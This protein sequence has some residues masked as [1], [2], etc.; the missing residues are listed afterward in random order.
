M[1]SEPDSRGL[2][3][4]R[5][6]P[7]PNYAKHPAYGLLFGRVTLQKRLAAIKQ[8]KTGLAKPIFQLRIHLRKKIKRNLARLRSRLL[9]RPTRE[10]DHPLLSSLGENGAVSDEL[11]IQDMEP[12]YNLLGKEIEA[13]EG[14]REEKGDGA[15]GFME[16]VT[17]FNGLDHPELMDALSALFER[18]GYLELLSGYMGYDL[19]VSN[20]NLQINNA[21]DTYWDGRFDD[22]DVSYPATRYMHID[23]QIGVLKA[24]IYLSSVTTESGPFCYVMGSN[25][26]TSLADRFIRKVNDQAGLDKRDVETRAQYWALPAVLRRK[27]ELGYDL[28]D[29]SADVKFLLSQEIRFTSDRGNIVLFDGDRGLHRGAMITSGTRRILQVF[30]R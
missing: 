3:R 11:S 5:K 20:A 6:L 28:E 1:N 10:Y 9:R 29:G 15:R 12:L 24:I 7:A 18:R 30:V 21:T 14:R 16:N 22:V 2:V 13:L 17:M 4:L 25:K 27:A 19:S 23:S 8:W 26:L